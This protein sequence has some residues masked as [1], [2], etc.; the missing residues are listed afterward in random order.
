[1]FAKKSHSPNLRESIQQQGEALDESWVT[2][3][4]E[5]NELMTELQATYDD[6]MRAFKE[7]LDRRRDRH[8][9]PVVRFVRHNP[10]VPLLAGAITITAFVIAARS[11]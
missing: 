10:W 7:I 1:M 4:D 5:A 3:K 9:K 6:I 11:R 2:V 8:Q